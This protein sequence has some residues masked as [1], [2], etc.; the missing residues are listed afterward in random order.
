MEGKTYLCFTVVTVSDATLV[1]MFF[2]ATSK[3]VHIVA[4]PG[5]IHKIQSMFSTL[6]IN[7]FLLEN[8]KCRCTLPCTPLAATT[9]APSMLERPSLSFLIDSGISLPPC[10]FT[11]GANSRPTQPATAHTPST[12]VTQHYSIRGPLPHNHT[13]SVK[14]TDWRQLSH[15]ETGWLWQLPLSLAWQHGGLWWLWGWR[16]WVCPLEWCVLWV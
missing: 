12:A 3:P 2:A 15:L 4:N 10:F 13:R 6:L 8:I 9:M 16:G 5:Q 1:V 7:N 11:C 14:H